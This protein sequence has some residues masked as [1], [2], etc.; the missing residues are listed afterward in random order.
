MAPR[1]HG[2]GFGD[3]FGAALGPTH[4]HLGSSPVP[5]R[6]R[7]ARIAQRMRLRKS[8]RRLVA[9]AG[10]DGTETGR[11]WIACA[12]D[13]NGHTKRRRGYDRRHGS[14]GFSV[15]V[16]ERRRLMI[17]SSTPVIESFGGGVETR[18]I[19]LD[20]GYTITHSTGRFGK[21]WH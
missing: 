14:R 2:R 5:G 16:I 7:V 10:F 21:G 3:L 11:P 9:V 19:C 6:L 17:V 12:S 4:V 1:D 8:D 15:P 13:P 20:C 18:Y